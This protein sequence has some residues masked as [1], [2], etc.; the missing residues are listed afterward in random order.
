MQRGQK[1]RMRGRGPS[2]QESRNLQESGN[3]QELGTPGGRTLETVLLNPVPVRVFHWVFAA[4]I[5]VLLVTG[6]Y[7]SRPVGSLWSSLAFM[8]MNLARLLHSAA[9]FVAIGAVIVRVYWAFF[10]GDY[11]EFLLSRQDIRDLGGFARYYLFLSDHMPSRGK[12]NVGQKATYGSWLVV[13]AFQ[14]I[15]G[16]ILRSP[17]SLVRAAGLLGGLEVVRLLHFGAAVWFL[18][19]VL[20]HIY[21]ALTEDPGRLQAMVTGYVRVP[22]A[23]VPAE[24]LVEG[25]AAMDESEYK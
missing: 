16:L 6:F 12:Y 4:C 14:V 7:I 22:V 5:I 2:L 18:A 3:L 21:L 9:A 25:G 20:V 17:Y 23:A 11:R 19:T 1:T 10:S 24:S 15:S 13:F 8:D